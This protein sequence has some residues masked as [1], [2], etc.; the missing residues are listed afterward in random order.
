MAN[1]SVPGLIVSIAIGMMLVAAMY[2]GAWYF[3]HG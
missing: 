2:V 3:I 1:D